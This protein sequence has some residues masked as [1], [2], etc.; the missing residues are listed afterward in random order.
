MKSDLITQ[1]TSIRDALYRE[2]AQ[3]ESRLR[4][5]DEALG[6]P[7]IPDSAGTPPPAA[8]PVQPRGRGRRPKGALSLRAAV[9][10]ATKDRPLTKPE[11]LRAVFKL[12]FRTTA[13]N[14]MHALNNLLYGKNPRFVNLNG[15][16]RPVGTEASAGNASR[17]PSP[18]RAAGRRQLTAAGR[19]KLSAAAKARWAKIKQAGG[20][21]LKAAT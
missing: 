1:Y 15:R 10:E 12:G 21:S 3:I 18:A 2:K 8:A 17:S 20:T 9:L 6:Q 14:P 19:A 13:A 11:I 16:F 4:Q 7:P 5:I